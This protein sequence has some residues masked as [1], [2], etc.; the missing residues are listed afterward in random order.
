MN[1]PG[2]ARATGSGGC[3]AAQLTDRLAARLRALTEASGR[4]P[5]LTVAALPV[6][7]VPGTAVRR[8]AAKSA[9]VEHSRVQPVPGTATIVDASSA[10][11]ASYRA[12]VA[13]KTSGHHGCCRGAE[14]RVRPLDRAGAQLLDPPGAL[15]RSEAPA[16]QVHRAQIDSLELELGLS[17]PL[18]GAA[19]S[20]GAQRPC[21][22]VPRAEVVAHGEGERA[23]GRVRALAERGRQVDAAAPTAAS[24]DDAC[25]RRGSVTERKSGWSGGRC[26]VLTVLIRSTPKRKRQISRVACGVAPIASRDL[27]RRPP[28]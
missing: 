28:G 26:H 17:S 3:G 20:L 14:Q 10:E 7:A 9:A 12:A 22:L 15:K 18:D 4:L 19:P 5:T 21:A 24:P 16:A 23:V 8:A 6:V 13:Q 27:Q 11:A 2:T 1:T 25:S